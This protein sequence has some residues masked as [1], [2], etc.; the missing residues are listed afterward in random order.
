MSK[1]G[2]M[3]YTVGQLGGGCRNFEF[4]ATGKLALRGQALLYVCLCFLRPLPLPR[5]MSKGNGA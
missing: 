1:G 4:Y 3:S 2:G 5:E